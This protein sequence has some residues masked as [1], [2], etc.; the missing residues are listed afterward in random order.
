[1]EYRVEELAREAGIR[2]DTVRFYQGRGLIPPPRR[3]GRVA[4]YGDE[5]LARLRRI[6]EWS[7]AGV[8]L[9]GIRRLLERAPS[10]ESDVALRRA[11]AEEQAGERTLT[12]AE[13]SA[14]AGVPEPLLRAAESAG[15]LV[16]LRV[17]GEAR[18]SEA[19][20]E[21]A[22][23]GLSILAAGFPLDALLRLAVDHSAEVK[24]VCERA[25]DLFDAY[26]R[27]A[28]QN[29]VR[30]EQVEESFR[31]LLPEVTRLVALHF[32]RTLVNRALERLE[33]RE[34]LEGLAQAVA[35][36]ESAQLEVKW[37]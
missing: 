37:K 15:L 8:S 26:V 18:F 21:M 6:R 35:A 23:S 12:R 33:G 1:V 36:M 25:I 27:R 10:G 3:R 30:P 4:I 20:L 28:P 29:G 5:H 14:E 19:D 22:R 9:A 24:A 34:E 2:V 32:Q 13:L 7:E 16:P 31:A 11:L 17:G